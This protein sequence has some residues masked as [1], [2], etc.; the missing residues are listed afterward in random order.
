LV[1]AAAMLTKRGNFFEF[2]KL[3]HGVQKA[4]QDGSFVL[5]PT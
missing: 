5:I 4:T 1:K 3:S 2:E